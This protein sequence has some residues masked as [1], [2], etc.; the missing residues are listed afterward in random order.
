MKKIVAYTLESIKV[1]LWVALVT[2]VQYAL[3]IYTAVS[4]TYQMIRCGGGFVLTEGKGWV[5]RDP[6]QQ[7]TVITVLLLNF[8]NL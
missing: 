3:H 2:P 7:A 5:E 4:C 1:C 6:G 8:S